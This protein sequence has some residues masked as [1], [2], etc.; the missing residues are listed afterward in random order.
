MTFLVYAL[1][2]IIKKG[3]CFMCI[4]IVKPAGANIPN[5]I[6]L[7]NCFSNNP[8]GAG[9][10][11]I[12]NNQL[13]I[14]KGFM[15]FDSFYDAFC[16]E[17]FTNNDVLFIHFRIATHGLRDGGN[18]HPF[19]VTDKINIL[20]KQDLS[21]SGYGLIHNGILSFPNRDFCKYDESMVIS[22]TMLFS[23]K[24]FDSIYKDDSFFL[25]NDRDFVIE[26]VKQY[27]IEKNLKIKKRVDYALGFNKIAILNNNGDWNIFGEW[28][29]DNGV[30]FSNRDYKFNKI[31]ISK[32]YNKNKNSC[33][34]CN[35]KINNANGIEIGELFF[36][37]DC[38]DTF[39]VNSIP[40][41]D[42]FF[43]CENCKSKFHN[44]LMADN[45]KNVCCNC[46]KIMV[47]KNVRNH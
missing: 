29:E 32:T 46:F 12:R 45:A 11:F 6:T 7:S 26:L 20:R 5:E 47:A 22:D 15:T 40:L 43:T 34:I 24:L 19:P 2:Y 41:K 31:T 23:L 37:W 9:F 18:T 1:F 25:K 10:M 36:C 4:A 42:Q 3:T 35:K 17:Q 16:A 28:I 14:K 39:A 27:L 30:F 13:H 44:S 38:F 33:C 21:F 8:H